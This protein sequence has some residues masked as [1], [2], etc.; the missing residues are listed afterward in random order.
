MAQIN[1]S[2]FSKFSNNEAYAFHMSV[3]D[4]AKEIQKPEVQDIIQKHGEAFEAF[5]AAINKTGGESAAT[6][7]KKADEDRDNGWV[8]AH[9]Y[10]RCMANY[11]PDHQMKSAAAVLLN[12]FTKYGNPTDLSYTAETSVLDNLIQDIETKG[13]AIAS[14]QFDLWLNHLKS[15]HLNYVSLAK[16]KNAQSAQ[17]VVGAV[18][19]ARIQCENAYGQMAALVNAFILISNG[20]EL[21]DFAR[22][23]NGLLQLRRI[24][25]KRSASLNAK[26][27]TSQE[28]GVSG[29]GEIS[30]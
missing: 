22:Q 7:A 10:L 3:A 20:D 2:N 23:V 13:E 26:D 19:A 28:K 14:A 6:L 17:K 29:D 30:P 21:N 5:K 18:K 11:C 25:D 9:A 12:I 4:L 27:D 16:E 24:A 1:Q 8:G 15:M